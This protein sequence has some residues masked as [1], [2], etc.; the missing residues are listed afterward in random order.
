MSW[1]S[2]YYT[3]LDV[4]IP[5]KMNRLLPESSPITNPSALGC[6]EGNAASALMGKKYKGVS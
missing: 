3:G 2:W 4:L 6:M 5:G 1:G